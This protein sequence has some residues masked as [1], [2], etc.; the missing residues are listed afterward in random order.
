MQ[1]SKRD[2]KNFKLDIKTRFTRDKNVLESKV[3]F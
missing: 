2:V 1:Q 3:I